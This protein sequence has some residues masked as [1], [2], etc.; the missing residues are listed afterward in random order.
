M[1]V[2]NDSVTGKKAVVASPPEGTHTVSSGRRKGLS[3]PFIN[4]ESP[5]QGERGPKMNY[6]PA[7]K[8]NHLADKVST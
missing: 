8:Y 1:S 2:K 4:Y 6:L 3:R 5:P 7:S